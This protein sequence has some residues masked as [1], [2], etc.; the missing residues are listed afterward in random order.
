[1]L[2][3]GDLLYCAGG[4]S[5]LFLGQ[6]NVQNALFYLCLN[7]FGI[8]VVGQKQGLLEFLV[9]EFAA[10]VASVFLTFLG[11]GFL[12][13]F[14]VQIVLVIYVDLEVILV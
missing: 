12:L 4:D 13:H 2:L 11:L 10:Q 7:L 5:F 3:D 14:D 9:G 1:M 8:Y 6:M